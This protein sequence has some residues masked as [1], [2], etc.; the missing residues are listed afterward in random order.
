MLSKS[1][2]VKP[3]VC[4]GELNSKS[5]VRFSKRNVMLVADFFSKVSRTTTRQTYLNAEMTELS[6]RLFSRGDN[7]QKANETNDN[8]VNVLRAD[9]K[10]TGQHL[11]RLTPASSDEIRKVLVKSINIEIM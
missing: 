2:N 1:T 8:V 7:L 6:N 10:I 9:V 4:G 3:N 5:I 11:T